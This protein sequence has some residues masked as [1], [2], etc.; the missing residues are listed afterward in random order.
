MDFY[1]FAYPTDPIVKGFI[2]HSGTAYLPLRG[3]ATGS[4]FS[5]VADQV[6]CEGHADSPAEQLACMR[7]VPF[8][9]I[10]TFIANYS[11]SGASP[12]LSFGPIADEKSFFSNYTERA[13]AKKQANLVS[14]SSPSPSILKS[15]AYN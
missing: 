4:N 5:Y 15:Q 1:N 14:R 9:T 3:D 2:M 12:S 11:N 7:S 13:L 6:G 10:N 8:E